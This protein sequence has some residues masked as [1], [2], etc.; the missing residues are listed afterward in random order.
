MSTIEIAD[1]EFFA[2]TDLAYELAGIRMDD[3][4]RNLII[5]RLS[6][7]L[8]TLQLTSML[9]YKD[10]LLSNMGQEKQNFINALTT[11]LTSF[12]RESHH[13]D[14]L[15]EWAQNE[16]KG[17]I[18]IWSTACSTG[19]E[20]Y[21]A[22]MTMLDCNAGQRCSIL[23]TDIDTECLSKASEG[24]YRKAD[25]KDLSRELLSRHFMKGVGNNDGYVRVKD[26]VRNMLEFSEFNLS[27][28]WSEV[29]Q[30]HVIFCRNVFIYFDDETQ[31]RILQHFC[32]QLHSGGILFLGHSETMKNNDGSFVLDRRSAYRRSQS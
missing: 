5:S 1:A 22:A 27:D 10:Y 23:A 17:H 7:R 16:H 2:F 3:S 30:F 8:R 29:G 14:Y 32:K 18:K 25:V 21:S 15:R 20:A 6:R 19:Q 12:Y 4:K 26:S 13:F 28:D 9:E 11:N 31:Q 24:V